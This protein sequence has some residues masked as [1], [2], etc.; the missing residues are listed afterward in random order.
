MPRKK[1]GWSGKRTMQIAQQLYEGVDLGG[2]AEGLIT[3][4]R[5]DSVRVSQTAI[6]AVRELISPAFRRGLSA[7]EPE[8]L[9]DQGRR[10]GRA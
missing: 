1:L 4:M 9:Q 8:C 5:T 10:P 7:R 2:G 6:D 3:Y